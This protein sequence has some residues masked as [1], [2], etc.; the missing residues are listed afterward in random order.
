[1]YRKHRIT[2]V[3]IFMRTAFLNGQAGNSYEENMI[4]CNC[5][6]N[7]YLVFAFYTA[8]QCIGSNK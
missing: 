4:R 3:G 1:M 8:I 6:S 2:K 5:Y 7:H